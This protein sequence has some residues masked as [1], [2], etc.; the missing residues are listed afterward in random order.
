MKSLT[1]ALSETAQDMR[2]VEALSAETYERIM[3]RHLGDQTPPMP[4]VIQTARSVGSGV[5]C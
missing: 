4:D 5:G 3:T 1:K 2:R